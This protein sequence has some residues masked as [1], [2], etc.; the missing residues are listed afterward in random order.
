MSRNE[1]LLQAL[2]DGSTVDFEP[3]SRAE[4]YLKACCNCEGTD[5]L[6]V[7]I[8]RN[9][10][11]LFKLAENISEERTNTVSGNTI[12]INNAAGGTAKITASEN[13]DIDVRNKNVFNA[14]YIG[15]PSGLY[16]PIVR[17]YIS[18]NQGDEYTI[19]FDTENT[20]VQCY[21][22]TNSGFSESYF[23]CNGNRQTI[24]LTAT[25]S[26]FNEFVTLISLG[27]AKEAGAISNIQIEKGSA[28]TE[29]IACVSQ[30]YTLA[31][32]AETTINI[33]EGANNIFSNT[34]SATLNLTYKAGA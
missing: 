24:T 11:L 33:S 3:Q 29:F 13:C 1:E 15:N 17:G 22:N 21:I 19:S 28:A 32:G 7:P 10:A 26:K 9:D 14:T 30:Q 12:Y 4:A 16:N 34:E 31:T 25:G 20:G 23:F 6:P 27:E 18:L 8:S 2:I 5:C